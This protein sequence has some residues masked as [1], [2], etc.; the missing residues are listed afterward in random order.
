MSL[1]LSG[2]DLCEVLQD[3][4]VCVHVDASESKTNTQLFEYLRPSMGLEYI[5]PTLTPETNPIFEEEGARSR[6]PH[7]LFASSL[8]SSIYSSCNT[9]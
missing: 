4:D 7:Q 3:Q 8:G 2:Q 1:Q 6:T 5:M 9:T